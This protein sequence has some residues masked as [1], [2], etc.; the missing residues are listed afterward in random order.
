MC[1]DAAAAAGY[2][3]GIRRRARPQLNDQHFEVRPHHPSNSKHLRDAVKLVQIQTAASSCLDERFE[4]DIH[5]Y[6]VAESEA[7]DHGAGH[8][9]HL[10]LLA[11]DAMLLDAKV[12]QRGRNPCQ[13]QRWIGKARNARAARNREPHLTRQLC[14][15]VVESQSG[16]QADHPGRHRPTGQSERVILGDVSARPAIAS[17]ADAFEFTSANHPCECA[18]VNALR[19]GVTNSQEP[20]LGHEAQ[21]I[22]T[23]ASSMLRHFAYKYDEMS[24]FCH[25][26]ARPSQDRYLL[27]EYPRIGI[28]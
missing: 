13:P 23:S 25:I 4:D 19:P 6:F 12:E 15:D 24:A 3:D 11:L 16:Q 2:S 18:G 9:R 21:H 14:P 7:V 20:A 8:A 22:R 1:S 27:I 26:A 28:I 5:S 17:R 10:D